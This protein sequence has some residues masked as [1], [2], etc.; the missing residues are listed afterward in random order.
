MA[1]NLTGNLIFVGLKGCQSVIELMEG[2]EAKI[3]FMFNKKYNG[4]FHF[5]Y[6]SYLFIK[7][8]KFRSY[9]HH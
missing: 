7:S 2:V 8:P 5:I 9:S 1:M 6:Y 3:I 4:I